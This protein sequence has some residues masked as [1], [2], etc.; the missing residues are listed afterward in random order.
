M[1]KIYLSMPGKEIIFNL[2]SLEYLI[3]KRVF[4]SGR[5]KILK[6]GELKGEKLDLI[7]CDE[8][9]NFDSKIILCSTPKGMSGTFKDYEKSKEV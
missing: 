6:Q 1:K 4:I 9:P 7:I 5:Y 8:A 2:G 3:L